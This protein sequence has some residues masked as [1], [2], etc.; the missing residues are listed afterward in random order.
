MQEETLDGHLAR[1]V[2]IDLCFACQAFW[3]DRHESLSLTPASTLRLFR[4][5]GERAA[6]PQV[7]GPD[8]AK[9]PRCRGRLRRTHDMQRATRFEYLR[10]PNGHGRLTTFFD[11]L[12]EKDFIRPLTA[13]QI[14]ELRDSLET[15]HCSNC[16]AVVD[17]A[18]GAACTHCGSPL[19]MLDMKQAEALIAQLQR[20]DRSHRSVDP[21]LPL[22][23][24]RARRE[25]EKAFHGLPRDPTWTADVSSLGL[26]GAG[27]SAVA[28]WFKTP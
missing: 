3:F 23:L 27:L 5:I 20:A 15:I 26:V 8:L 17:L 1:P 24:E 19:S 12:R 14:E 18:R 22:Q 16:G 10:C 25:V 21:T 7:P 2:V 28:R 13:P 9:C 6:K 11:F 4:V